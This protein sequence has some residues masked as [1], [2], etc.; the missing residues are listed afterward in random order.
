MPLKRKNGSQDR[1]NLLSDEAAET[2]SG[3]LIF[4]SIVA[5]LAS[6]SP[7]II[8]RGWG[9]L[10][11]KHSRRGLPPSPG[12]DLTNLSVLNNSTAHPLTVS[13]INKSASLIVDPSN[14]TSA[15]NN[16]TMAGM[17]PQSDGALTQIF[18]S[19]FHALHLDK[20]LPYLPALFAAATGA[21]LLHNAYKLKAPTRE[22]KKIE[23]SQPG[24]EKRPEGSSLQQK[25]RS[26]FT[27]ALTA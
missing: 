5:G 23:A 24:N 16:T 10:V 9:Y 7:F 22:L 27:R 18:G 19:S 26:A 20:A 14:G 17:F 11:E 15:L 8:V 12:T 2:S 25:I 21:M 3:F 1:P 13:E 4:T 6:V